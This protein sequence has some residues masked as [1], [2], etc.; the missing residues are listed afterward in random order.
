MKKICSGILVLALALMMNTPANAAFVVGGENGWQFSTDGFVNVFGVYQTLQKTPNGT[1]GGELS[2]RPNTTGAPETFGNEAQ[3]EF[4]VR[5]GLLPT[6]FGFNIKA[7]TTKGVDYAV[8]LGIY[9]Q[10]QNQGSGATAINTNVDF[11]EVNFTADGSFGQVLAGRAINLYQA[12]NIL[13]DM[14]LFSVGVV[15]PVNAGPTMGHIGYGY[16]YP[17]F[18]AQFRYTTPSLG[19]VKVAVSVND[20]HD[21]GA[22]TGHNVPR[23]MTEVSYATTFTGGKLQAW[24]SGQ[25]QTARF[26][27]TDPNRPGGS[28]TTIG[29]AGGVEVGLGGL[30]MLVSGY[31]GQA[32]GMLGLQGGDATDAVGKERKNWGFLTQA[33]Y[34]L[35]MDLKV[36]VNYG[37][38]NTLETDNDKVV[39]AAGTAG[40]K[41]QQAV[42]GTLTYNVNKFVQVIAEYTW[43]QDK[44]FAGQKQDANIV[45]L[46]TFIYW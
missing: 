43:A 14:T 8:R 9:P 26:S 27:D 15:G 23:F 31:G 46:G 13:T 16:L 2:G 3:Q 45:A 35:P 30:D 11:R 17:N 10:I 1:S 34:A 12:K 41:T 36:G 5:T 39:R 42:A 33:T 37:Q 38:S 7:P 19:G 18:D 32:L 44:W 20:P 24:L 22:A 21:I 6:A 28:A 29:G 4:Q 40:I 25:Y